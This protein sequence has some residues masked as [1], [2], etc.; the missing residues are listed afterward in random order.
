VTS[1]PTAPMP[2]GEVLDFGFGLYR[3]CW[4]VCV[5][6]SII[7]LV[8]LSLGEALVFEST[9]VPDNPAGADP[10][11][12]LVALGPQLTVFVAWS[13]A[14]AL[15]GLVGSAAVTAT[16]HG[17]ATG[18]SFS[19]GGAFRAVVSRLGALIGAHL[20]KL[21]FVVGAVIFATIVWLVI[22]GVILGLAGAGEGFVVA[23]ATFFVF[24]AAG[25]LGWVY[26][27]GRMFALTP[28][29]MIEGCRGPESVRRSWKLASGGAL[30]VGA[31]L[32]LAAFLLYTPYFTILA[33]TGALIPLLA[34]DVATSSG[35]W[36]GPAVGAIVS[37]AIW[38]L[39]AGIRLGFYYDR[40]VRTEGF[41]IEAA[42]RRMASGG[43]G[44]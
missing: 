32:I 27:E 25:A 39:A 23:L 20:I 44:R 35:S 10:V 34:G 8:P 33:L 40:R 31:V 11:A 7:A 13:F 3:R 15:M 19:V 37:A 16:M 21:V 42:A 17:S 2:T 9:L 30:K 1:I 22:N 5:P 12:A 24:L 14:S 4:R 26:I 29:L 36:M 43:P 41:D 18:Q 6:I 28:V 38:P